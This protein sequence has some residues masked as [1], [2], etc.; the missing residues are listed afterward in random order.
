MYSKD[1]I[2]G[3]TG[4]LYSSDAAWIIGR[5]QEKDG[6]EIVGYNFVIN[7]EKSRH[8]KEKSKIPISITH[9]GGIDKWSGLFDLALEAGMLIKPKMG[10]YQKVDLET[11]EISQESF[12]EK[13]IKADISYFE[14][15]LKNKKFAEFVRQKYKLSAPTI[16]ND[17]DVVYNEDDD[18]EE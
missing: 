4:V 6:T 1:V 9:K 2:S 18:G 13:A 16:S 14:D 17:P 10:W 12:R 8:V 5:Q 3:G 7:I 15:L 11:G